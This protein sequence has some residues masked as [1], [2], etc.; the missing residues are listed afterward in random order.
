MPQ[1]GPGHR[2]LAA[3][4]LAGL[5]P[6]MAIAGNYIDGVSVPACVAAAGRAAAAVVAAT[7]GCPPG[8]ATVVE[9]AHAKLSFMARLD[10]DE[11]QRHHPVSHVL[12]VRRAT[13]CSR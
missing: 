6:S 12:R 11:A 9:A 5:P 2:E 8:A 4:M 10:F 7:T 13:G 1:Y 3:E